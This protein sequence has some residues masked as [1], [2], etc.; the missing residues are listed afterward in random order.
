[1]F[2]NDKAV[3]IDTEKACQAIAG[4]CDRAELLEEAS[5]P[6][7][8]TY[9]RRLA[10]VKLS[11]ALFL[12]AVAGMPIY[13][14]LLLYERQSRLDLTAVSEGAP[15]RYAA[16]N[17]HMEATFEGFKSLSK[18]WAKIIEAGHGTLEI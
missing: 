6:G 2:A 8:M 4:L 10:L 14:N 11:E 16:L 17:T 18:I 7:A 12:R 9:A 13:S 1:M 15:G 3:L 5:A